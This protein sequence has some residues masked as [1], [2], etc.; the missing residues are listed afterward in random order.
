M[1]R[2]RPATGGASLADPWSSAT[3]AYLGMSILARAKQGGSA[4]GFLPLVA[5]AAIEIAPRP[6]E[7]ALVVGG[8]ALFALVHGGKLGPMFPQQPVAV[9][10]AAAERRLAASPAQR[11]AVSSAGH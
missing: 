8:P 2:A 10:Q 11:Q 4:N 7:L 5:L 6:S 1:K 9:V 3:V